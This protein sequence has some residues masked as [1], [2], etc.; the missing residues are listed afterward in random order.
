MVEMSTDFWKQRLAAMVRNF[1]LFS[2]RPRNRMMDKNGA[3]NVRQANIPKRRRQ[4]AK[5]GVLK[6]SG[7]RG[8]FA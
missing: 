5:S 8:A 6:I 7:G 2:K 3:V 4:F 1:D